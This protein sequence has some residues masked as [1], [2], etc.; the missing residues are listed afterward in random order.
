MKKRESFVTAYKNARN[1]E[2]E[3]KSQVEI[4]KH[5]MEKDDDYDGAKNIWEKLVK[6]N[7]CF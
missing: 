1:F 6:K 2:F 3:V 4:I 7:P 5:S